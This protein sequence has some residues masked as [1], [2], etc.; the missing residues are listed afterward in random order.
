MR[1][2]R[3]YEN[4]VH[5]LFGPA[6]ADLTPPFPAENSPVIASGICISEWPT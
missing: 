4:M 2:H 1:Y 5:T 3:T 6:V